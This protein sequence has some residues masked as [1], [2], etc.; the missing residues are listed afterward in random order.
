MI[1]TNY[2]GDYSIHLLSGKLFL[3]GKNA[4]THLIRKKQASQYAT[5]LDLIALPLVWANF[6]TIYWKYMFSL[7]SFW[8]RQILFE[9]IFAETGYFS[10]TELQEYS[11]VFLY[12]LSQ[13]RYLW[14]FGVYC[15]KVNFQRLW[16][17]STFRCRSLKFTLTMCTRRSL[18]SLLKQV[19][20]NLYCLPA[21]RIWI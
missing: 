14:D 17:M 16:A 21:E 8:M 18:A 7:N 10:L 19:L 11:S 2:D 6:K 1:F 9:K 4:R 20:K 15:Y 13:G 5:C 3:Q 12:T